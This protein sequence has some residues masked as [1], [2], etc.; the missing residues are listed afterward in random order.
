MPPSVFGWDF[1]LPG[2][3]IGFIK[4]KAIE[5]LNYLGYEWPVTDDGMLDS[6]GNQWAAIEGKIN[7]FVTD[8]QG[9]VE[10][11]GANNEGDYLVAFQAYMKGD[12]SNLSSLKSIADASPIAAASYHGAAT[13][14]RGLRLYVI[15]KLLLDAVMLAA[16]IISGGVS[17]GASF[18]VRKGIGAVINIA[19]D[20]A[21]NQLLGTA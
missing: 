15:G 19:I 6:W 3:P 21:I 1:D 4:G 11:I 2:D 8:L 10:Y 20:Q 16:A 18:L 5:L 17:A 12:E 14:I 13:L 7:G 9:G